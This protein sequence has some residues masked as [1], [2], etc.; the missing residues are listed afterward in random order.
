M[1]NKLRS[2]SKHKAKSK[3]K[4]KPASRR[5]KK[6]SPPPGF[7]HGLRTVVYFVD[8]VEAAMLWYSD[9]LGIQPYF[10]EPFY[11]GFNVGGYE[12]GLHPR[13]EKYPKGSSSQSAHWGVTDADAAY[14]RLLQLGALPYTPPED[15]G[16]GIKVAAVKD[17]FGNIL[18]IIENAKFKIG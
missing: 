18:A 15:V 9:V 13:D 8:D 3:K 14:A 5:P 1:P 2:K 16:D 7:F 10:A 17:P 4:G 11:V 6:P 12:L